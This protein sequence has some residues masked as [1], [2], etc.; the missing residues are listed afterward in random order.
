MV[1]GYIRVRPT[2]SK[3]HPVSLT[4]A[5]G[6]DEFIR[7]CWVYSH[8]LLGSLG[9]FGVVGF[10]RARPGG[11]SVYPWLLGSLVHHG[12]RWVHPGS[13]GSLSL[14][15]GDFGYIWGRCVHQGALWGVLG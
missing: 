13:L 10:A 12:C 15:M 1:F 7:S 11:Y 8:T 9:S 14:A 4:R 6:V 5:L 3:V 2:G